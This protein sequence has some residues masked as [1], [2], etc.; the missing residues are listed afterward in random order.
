MA[1]S[2]KTRTFRTVEERIAAKKAEL[3]ALLKKVDSRS[4]DQLAKLKSKR[5]RLVARIGELNK[6]IEEVDQEM[7]NLK[8][9][10]VGLTTDGVGEAEDTAAG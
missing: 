10:N 2:K 6:Q 1:D 4:S 7:A 3:D 8:V 9:N 5:D